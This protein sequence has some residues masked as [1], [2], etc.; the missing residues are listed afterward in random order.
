MPSLLDRAAPRAADDARLPDMGE[1]GGGGHNL[2]IYTV[3]EISGELKRTVEGRFAAVRVRGEISGFKRAAS[4]HCYLALKD[5]DALIDAVVWRGA[6][7]RL[8]FRPEDGLEVIATGRLTTYPGRSKY[9]LVVEQME[10]AGTGALMALIE[11]RRR[12]L[13]A[14]GLFDAARK[15]ALPFLPEVIGVVTSPTG[16]VIRDILHRLA[17]RFPR[18]VIIWPVLVQG[19]GAA[20]QVAAAIRGFDALVPGGA[21]PRPDLLIVARG[22]GSIEDLMAFNEEAVVRAAAACT[23]PLISAV[24][25]ETDTTLIDFVADLRAPT[26]T[27]AAEKAV[28]VLGDLLLEVGDLGARL[29]GAA[30]R[31]IERGAERTRGLARGLPRPQSLI[32]SATQRLDDRAERLHAG[33]D[34]VLERRAARVAELSARLKS[35]GER[36]AEAAGRLDLVLQRLDAAMHR[37]GDRATARL[38]RAA[39]GV[40]PAAAIR[41]RNLGAERLGGL[42]DRLHAAE[43]RH[44][45]NLADRLAGQGALLE[46]YSYR[47]ALARGFAL[48]ET[49]GEDGIDGGGDEPGRPLTRAAAIA[50]GQALSLVF[51]DG[52]V[53][54]HADGGAPPASTDA[55]PRPARP[56]ARP[57]RDPPAT[58]EQPK[59]F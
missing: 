37:I 50:A 15:Q 19:P 40:T 3:T 31:I 18:R 34:R 26:P 33:I 6:A 23:I 28:P 10:P 27:A 24:G 7:G 9:Q 2:P 1:S 8:S 44:L 59:L 14:E 22:G 13:A 43:A 17:E 48:V 45:R 5:E 16:A 29:P 30:F 54:A 41:A 47:R 25:H 21:I 52:R 57:R 20:D 11:D 58:G 51:A 55:T 32:D 36:F 35:P 38:D 53:A 4:G 49:A 39:A 12:R 56:A 42:S 46:S